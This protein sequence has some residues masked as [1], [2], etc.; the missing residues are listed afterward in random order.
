MLDS[1]SP[2]YE[3]YETKDGKY[4]AVGALE[5]QFYKLLLKGLFDN[6]ENLPHILDRDQWPTLKDI[7]AKRFKEKTR[8][9]WTETFAGTDACVSPVLH[10]NEID[11]RL[12]SSTSSGQQPSPSPSLSRTPAVAQSESP[13]RGQDTAQLL[14][15]LGISDADIDALETTSVV[16]RAKL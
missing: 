11:P 3:V 7:F 4:M 13:S 6:S 5:P 8:D 10:L 16:E 15:D 1:G 2:N 12:L 14:R 9:E